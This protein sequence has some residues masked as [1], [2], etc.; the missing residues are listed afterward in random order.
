MSDNVTYRNGLIMTALILGAVVMTWLLTELHFFS[1]L[2]LASFDHRVQV[3]RYDKSLHEDVVV[4][5]IDDNSLQELS[6]EFGRWPW[7]RAAYRDILEFFSLARAQALGFDIMFTEQQDADADNVNDRELVSATRKAGN[8]V[9][10]MQLMHSFDPAQSREMPEEFIQRHRIEDIDF[11]GEAYDDFLLPLPALSE[12]TR[13]VGYLKI[14]PDRD[15]VYRR[16]RLF[17]RYRDEAVFPAFSTALVLPLIS[18]GQGLVYHDDVA[19][20]GDTEIPLDGEGNYLINPVGDGQILSYSQISAAIKQI[21]AGQTENMEL[22]PKDFTNKIVLLGAS[23]ISLLD[24]KAT[25]FSNTQAGVFLH[26]STVSN[27]L[28]QDFLYPV[29][30]WVTYGLILLMSALAVI[31]VL[32]LPNMILGAL[33]PLLLGITYVFIAYMGFSSNYLFSVIPVVFALGFSLLLAFSYRSYTEKHNKQKIR[34]MFSQY[35]SPNVLTYVVDNAETLSAEIGSNETLSIL[36]SD[37]RGFT[38]ISETQDA[39][40]VVDMLNIYFSEMTDIIF[41][42][43]GTLDKF[44]GDAIM[45]FW[46]APIKTETHAD[47]AVHAAIA[48]RNMLPSVNE[49]LEK[50]GY[51]QIEIGIGVHTG[52]VVL[53]N[54]GSSKKLDYTVI[55][56]SVNLASRI[57]GITKQYGVPLIISE[58]TYHALSDN[59]P[60][61][62]VDVVRLKGKQHP[63]KLYTPASVFL[64]ESG[65]SISLSELLNLSNK[66]FE[67]Y[68]AS[69]WDE[70]M[71]IYQQLQGCPLFQ[72]LADRCVYYQEH[73]PGKDWDGVYTHTSK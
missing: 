48:M 27:I 6:P 67:Y 24:V 13:D 10:A 61:I 45:A 51:S 3:F 30:K 1:R 2:E 54:I 12:A 4:V 16:V 66:A 23:A 70:A 38:Q 69:K 39:Q 18:N 25:A 63:I 64:N 62:V 9:H 36:F 20:M 19:I 47:Q 60:C 17:D 28:E 21:R 11:E 44:I 41:E 56:D 68:Q 32:L 43:D 50:M 59:L 34:A 15:G 49:K 40:K 72:T 53:G 14:T 8:T 29:N 42:H 65:L 22:D 33:I 37:I 7:P 26:A 35:V 46:G 58:D 52:K 57:E 5:L 31:P 71:A 73:E 55:G